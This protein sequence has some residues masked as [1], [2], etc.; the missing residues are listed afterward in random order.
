MTSAEVFGTAMLKQKNFQIC[1]KIP[2]S[3]SFSCK[4]YYSIFILNL[5][6]ES[7]LF[8]LDKFFHNRN[9]NP[10]EIM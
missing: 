10:F 8:Y 4:L 3:N 5:D 9:T 6:Q 2:L 1:M 7:Y